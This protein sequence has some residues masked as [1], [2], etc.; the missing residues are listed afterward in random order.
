M[1]KSK[2]IFWGIISVLVVIFFATF[3]NFDNSEAFDSIITFLSITTGFSI[4]AL[5][6]IA[7]STF[8]KQLYK[9]E[10]NKDNS[11][12]LLHTLVYQFKNSTLL[13]VATIALILLYYFIDN[14]EIIWKTVIVSNRD[15]NF[16]IILKSTIWYLTILSLWN[17]IK[18]LLIFSKF[19]IKNATK[20]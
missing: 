17:V 18:L 8:S 11:K 2:K 14:K 13:F 15:F 20:G 7:S 1:R 6:I 9:I 16:P 12:T 5:S 19:V 4:T 3:L 10:E